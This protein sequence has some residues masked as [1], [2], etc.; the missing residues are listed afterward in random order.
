MRKTKTVLT[1]KEIEQRAEYVSILLSDIQ[2]FAE[3]CLS[4]VVTHRIPPFHS[5]LYKV[6]PEASRLIVAAPRGF[7]KSKISSVIYPIWLA[8]TGNKRE[9]VIIS[10]SETLAKE[11]LR[12]IKMELENNQ[13]II[14]LFGD[15]RTDKWSETHIITT[16]GV[17]I[18]ARGAGGQIRGFRPDCLLFDDIETDETVK[19]EEQRKK[20]KDWMMKAAI[21]TLTPNG[22]M[23][24]V[25]SIIDYLALL[26]DLLEIDNG[27]TKMR[28]MA[29]KD[30]N[31]KLGNE[32]WPE[33]WNHEKLQQRKKDIGSWAFAAE[34]M[35]NPISDESAPIRPEQ[36]RLWK[37][38]PDDLSC[39][40][41]V[42]P[43]Y[44]ED[45]KAD[46]KVASLVGMDTKHNRYMIQ[47][48]RTHAP[49]SEFFNSIINMWL[50]NKGRVTAVGIPNSGTEKSFFESFIKYCNERGVFPPV[51]EL[52][53]TFLTASGQSVRNK[54]DRVVA[55]LQPLFEQGKYFINESHMEVRDEL[56]TIGSSRWDDLVD[57]MAYAE[58]ILTPSFMKRDE[59]RSS[60]SESA[61]RPVVSTNYGY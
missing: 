23:V 24:M 52:K 58:N 25:G 30:F 31:E 18:R 56:L 60:L 1:Q 7:A 21:P 43:A 11:M 22:Q 53:N 36:I 40:I 15:L 4:S 39:V 48:V 33:L 49:S 59:L 51:V 16:T 17:S 54:R 29:Y 46:Y 6:L 50:Q 5:D 42:D 26:N 10:A 55:A 8:C 12:Q 2:V 44:S 61:T 47:Y 27:W 34:Y 9:L 41:A 19:S 45:E 14:G 37:E 38:L 35:N 32:T 3:D 20:L 28:I 57:T 13:A